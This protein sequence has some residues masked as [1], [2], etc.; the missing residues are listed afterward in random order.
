M[1]ETNETPGCDHVLIA[2]SHGE[3]I[4]AETFLRTFDLARVPAH[5]GCYLM[6]DDTGKV[7]YVGK[8]VHLRSR[9][10]SYL[11]DQDTRYRVKFLMRRVARIDF[12]VTDTEKEALLLENSLIKEHQPRYNVRLK[13]DKTHVSLKL[14]LRHAWPRFTVTRKRVK[15]G[16]R[17][18]GPY[19]SAVAV[20]ETLKQLQKVFPLRTCPD[21]VLNNR[22]RPCLYHQ[23]GQCS[24]PCVGLVSSEDYRDTVR[25]AVLVLEGRNA[26][27]EKLLIEKIE[28]HAAALEFEKA[29]QVRDRLY[30]LRETLERQ[31]T[32][33]DSGAGDQDVFG[34]HCQGRY[35]VIQVLTYRGGRMTGGRPYSFGRQEMPAEEVFAS[36]LMQYYQQSAAIPDEVLVPFALEE[37]A[38]LAELLSDE[39]GRKVTVHCPERGEKRTLVALAERN[40]R[41]AFE[42]KRLAEKANQDLTEQVG[43]VFQLDPPPRRIECFD[44]SNVQGTN[45]VG[46]MVVFEGGV[47]DKSRYRR[48][49]IRLVEGQDDFAMMREVLLRRYTRAVAEDDLPGLVLIDGGKGQLNVAVAVFKDLGI[50]NQPVA[51]IAKARAL[52]EGGHSP[53]RFFVPG[54]KNPIILPQNHPVVLYLARVRDEAHRFAVTYHRQ[55][56]TTAALRSALVEI[57]GVGEKR[58]RALLRA[59]GS[60]K[61]IRESGVD[62][63][64]AVPGV[65]ETLARTILE[66]LQRAGRPE[67]SA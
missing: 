37:A 6:R 4:D 17:Y 44:I 26:D 35:S 40:A 21:A 25:Q 14:N 51:G 29:A 48:F 22:T 30:A 16:S 19:A 62:E 36:F 3:S 10:R 12:L 1:S 64:A 27:V 47:P 61:R 54:R 56:R 11:N 38:T 28:S 52:D 55:R 45:A 34:M 65:S 15:D 57:P 60:V 66:H 8:A 59:L 23:I 42:E 49:S 24:A 63:I 33:R 58:A 53:E 13:D 39:R 32:V 67:E 18:F 31:R 9:I 50:D 2:D 20:R 43:R 41:S 7:V 46:S 5:P